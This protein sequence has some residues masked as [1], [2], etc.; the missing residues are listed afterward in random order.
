MRNSDELTFELFHGGAWHRAF[1]A[2]RVGEGS[3]RTDPTWLEYE[4]DYATAHLLA[5]DR[6][7]ASCRFPVGYGPRHLPSFPAFF[8]DLLPQ[9]EAR[10]SLGARLRAAGL[11]THDWSLLRHG[12]RSPVGN[13]RVAVED[14]AP[15]SPGVDREVV[16]ARGD[17]FRDWAEREGIPMHGSSDTGGAAPKLLL[18]EDHDGRL[19]ADGALPDARAAKHYL[20]K[21]PRGRTSADARI[22]AHEPAYLELARRHGVR[23]G[24]ALIHDRGT[25]FVPRFDRACVAGGGSLARSPYGATRQESQPTIG[26]ECH[27]ERFGLESMYALLD[28]VEPGAAL[29][30]EDVCERVASVV[31]DPAECVLE[32]AR[33]DALDLAFDNPDNHGRNTSVLKRADGTITLSPL[34]DFGPMYLDPDLVKRTT[35]WRFE[36]PGDP[37]DWTGVADVL[38]RWADRDLVIATLHELGHQL[39]DARDAMR[40]LDVD[41]EIVAHCGPRIDAVAAGL[42]AAR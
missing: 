41:E 14:V 8:G 29:A 34:Y 19:H 27:V 35:R 31:D 39:A 36:H 10:R 2:G 20:V 4:I 13:A 5:R 40:A 15:P 22:L 24:E 9:G 38:A 1:S 26:S 17:T 23:C 18:T 21:F 16:I 6:R 30:W 37:P 33:R 7:A 25:L 42:K 12:A 32:L 11:P 3:N 28:V